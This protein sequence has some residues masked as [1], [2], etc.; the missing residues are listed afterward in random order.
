MSKDKEKEPRRV[1]PVRRQSLLALLATWG[2]L[3][4]EFPPIPDLP[5][6]DDADK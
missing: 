4:E 5:L 6:T 3:D 2:P 1:E